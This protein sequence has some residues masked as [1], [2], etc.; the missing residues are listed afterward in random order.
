M[1]K[2]GRVIFLRNVDTSLGRIC[3]KETAIRRWGEMVT[4]GMGKG[5]GR[6]WV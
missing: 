1:R 3:V 2:A 6:T 5:I 4:G